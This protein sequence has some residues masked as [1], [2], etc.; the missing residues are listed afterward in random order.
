MT[1]S[2]MTPAST[3]TFLLP[4]FPEGY[5][6]QTER[7][8]LRPPA[9]EDVDALWPHVS[10]PR[11]TRFL[12]W[13]PHPNKEVTKSMLRS[14]IEAQKQGKGFHWIVFRGK[15]LLGIL[16]LIDV[17]RTHRCW[18]LDRAELAYWLGPACQG[19][20]YATEAARWV[21]QFAFEKLALHKVI[22]YHVSENPS[23]GAVAQRLGFRYI[24]EEME[25]FQK[26]GH[27]YHLKHY[28]MLKREFCA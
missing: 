7:L 5:Q 18:T 25:A 19:F 26:E 20:G 14:L 17:R 27:W 23:S 22:V 1:S 12:A 11:I 28:E 4:H 6:L 8:V 10:D 15:E 9:L 21:L 2:L 3:S 16:S 24:G 13:G